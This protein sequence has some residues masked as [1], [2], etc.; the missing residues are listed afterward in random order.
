MTIYTFTHTNVEGP[1]SKCTRML[2]PSFFSCSTTESRQ[3]LRI[4]ECKLSCTS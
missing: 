2:I 4:S 3:D 1:W